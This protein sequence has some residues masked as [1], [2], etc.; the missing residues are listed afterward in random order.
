ME[1][2]H[3]YEQLKADF[4]ALPVEEVR[5]MPAWK[6]FEMVG[7]L[8]AALRAS[9]KE[10][11]SARYPLATAEELGKRFGIVWL[12]HELAK[13]AFGWEVDEDDTDLLVE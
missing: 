7:Q 1:A 13:T 6:K 8:T 12:G 10:G 9:I 2:Q 11:L 4:A 3:A 5:D